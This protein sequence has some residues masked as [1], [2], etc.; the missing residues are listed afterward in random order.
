[1]HPA[2][3]D[4][5]KRVLLVARDYPGGLAYVRPRA[6]ALFRE[7]APEG[8]EEAVL[9]AVARGRWYVRNEMVPL[10]QLKKYRRINQRYNTPA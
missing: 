7:G 3:R 5:Y 6:K 2:V 8:D 1:M 4:L 9:Q 10:I